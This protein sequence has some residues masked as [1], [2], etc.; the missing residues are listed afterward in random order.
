LDH[1]LPNRPINTPL[2]VA[3]QDTHN[4]KLQFSAV[5]FIVHLSFHLSIEC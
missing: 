1:L 2:H 3:E 4:E 5:C